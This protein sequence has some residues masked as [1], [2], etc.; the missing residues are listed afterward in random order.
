MKYNIKNITKDEVTSFLLN[1][2]DKTAYFDNLLI[3]KYQKSNYMDEIICLETSKDQYYAIGA[4]LYDNQEI[5]LDR[6]ESFH[7][8]AIDSKYVI[9]AYQIKDRI[10]QMAKEAFKEFKERKL[11]EIKNTDKFRKLRNDLYKELFSP[12]VYNKLGTSCFP[13][14]C[15]SSTNNRISWFVDRL[16]MEDLIEIHRGKLDLI[17]SFFDELILTKN[18]MDMDIIRPEIIVKAEE[19]IAKGRFSK[20]ERTLIDY[21]QK[22]KDSGAMRFT[23]QTIS[24]E[25]AYCHNSVDYMGNVFTLKDAIFDIQDIDTVTYRGKAIYKKNTI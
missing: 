21:I 6:Y 5:V 24:G 17:Y 7:E 18:F 14:L 25:K 20:R 2:F 11:D 10:V 22:T 15:K 12:I 8:D 23:V 1:P 3:Q 19:Y 16:S 13:V 4:V 9:K